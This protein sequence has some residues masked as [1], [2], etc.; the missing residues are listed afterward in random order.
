MSIFFTFV[1]SRVVYIEIAVF[2][3]NDPVKGMFDWFILTL[4]R[5]DCVIDP[6]DLYCNV[7]FDVLV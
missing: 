6:Y 7:W 1:F 5:K 2:S 4:S 3:K